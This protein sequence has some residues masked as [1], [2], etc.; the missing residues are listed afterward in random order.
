M[1]NEG[2]THIVKTQCNFMA[3][4]SPG[5]AAAGWPPLPRRHRHKVRHPTPGLLGWCEGRDGWNRNAING[6]P[7]L[8]LHHAP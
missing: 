8:Q 6:S 7:L 4:C 3:V 2:S 5:L 1:N